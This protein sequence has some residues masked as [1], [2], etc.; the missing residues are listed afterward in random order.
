LDDLTKREVVVGHLR[1]RSRMAF[2]RARGMIVWKANDHEVRKAAVRLELAQ[3]PDELLGSK[4]I[5]Y[6]E[7]PSNGVGAE[8]RS[9]RFD[10]RPAADGDVQVTVGIFLPNVEETNLAFLA[11]IAMVSLFGYE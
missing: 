8:I 11:V 6:I 7:V 5:R 9:E 10:R 1:G 2:L 4:H 3:L